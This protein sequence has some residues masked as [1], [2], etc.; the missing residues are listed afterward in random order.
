MMNEKKPTWQCP[1]C[2]QTARYE[3][4]IVDEWVVLSIIQNSSAEITAA[5]PKTI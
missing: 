4:L 5:V 2:D 1:V 3:D